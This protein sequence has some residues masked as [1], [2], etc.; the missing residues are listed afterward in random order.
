[1]ES[2]YFTQEA[3]A[4]KE[5]LVHSMMPFFL[6]RKVPFEEV[7]D[8]LCINDRIYPHGSVYLLLTY[9]ATI[10][11]QRNTVQTR[12]TTLSRYKLVDMVDMVDLVDNLMA[13]GGQDH[14]FCLEFQYRQLV[15]SLD[16]ITEKMSV[17]ELRR[18]DQVTKT[19]KVFKT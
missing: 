16:H 7:V 10:I 11:G 6:V 13:P 4:E 9:L 14:P 18:V 3:Q 8:D 5:L 17:D 1:M 12:I 15:T 19:S 2:T